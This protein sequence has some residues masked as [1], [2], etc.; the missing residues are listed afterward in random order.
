MHEILFWVIIGII[1]IDFIFEKYLDY[2]NTTKWSDALPDEVKGIYDEAK[3]KTQ[4]A[5]QREN[6]RFGILTSSF[7]FIITLGM[8]LFFGFAFVDNIAWGISAN[9]IIAA[10]IFFGILMFVSDIINT[11]FSVYD[12]FKIEEKYGFNKTTPKTFV[13]DK[14]K[15]WLVGALI[16]GGLLALIIFIYQKTQNMFWIYAWITI[17][18]FTIFMAMFYSNLI[19]PLFNKQIPLEDGE[20]RDAIKTFSDKVGFKLDNIFVINGS[21]RST[22]ANAYFTGLGA[23]KRIVLYDTLINDMEINELVA[24]LAHEIGHYKKKHVIQG[25]LISLAQTGVVLFI[26]SLLINNPN[27]SKA[28]GVDIPNFHIGLV[29]FGILYSPV[30]FVL[31]I[32]MNILSRKNEYQAD[33]FAAV[34]FNPVD[35]ASA[36]KK[37]SVKNLSN[38]TPHKKY[39]FFHYSHPTLLQRLVYLKSFEKK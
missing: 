15:G 38:L 16:G 36:L 3:Y 34:N 26:F 27:L 29:A 31:G 37:L 5:Y 18:A 33:E 11:P 20:L 39:V 28:L 12:T 24:V 10:L 19:V 17:S 8:F 6:H 22:K 23:K 25:L 30:S 21:K 32:F 7:S 2:L 1:V 13:F 35:L 14:I 4:Q 9:S